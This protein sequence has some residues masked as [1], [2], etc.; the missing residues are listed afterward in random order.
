[1]KPKPESAGR[2]NGFMHFVVPTTNIS[3][4][5]L[6]RLATGGKLRGNRFLFAGYPCIPP[7]ELFRLV[8]NLNTSINQNPLLTT[9]GIPQSRN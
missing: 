1:M 2:L 8:V 4:L 5:D 3:M 6:A 7:P 9:K